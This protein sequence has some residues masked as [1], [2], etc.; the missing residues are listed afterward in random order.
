MTAHQPLSSRGAGNSV[1]SK[2]CSPQ[3][4]S[5]GR[6]DRAAVLQ[7][8][9]KLAPKLQGTQISGVSVQSCRRSRGSLS[10]RVLAETTIA[11]E[12]QSRADEGSDIWGSLHS[13][14]SSGNDEL[15]A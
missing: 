11:G 2:C 6:R 10:L 9:K 4:H 5:V 3:G 12:P 14:L 8:C 15:H 7:R 13:Q 1:A